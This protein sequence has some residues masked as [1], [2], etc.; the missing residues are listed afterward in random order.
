[1][2]NVGLKFM[3]Q[4]AQLPFYATEGA[5]G[6][7][8]T[9]VSIQY[10]NRFNQEVFPKSTE[11]WKEVTKVKYNLGLAFE[12]PK[13]YAI[14]LFPRSSVMK[15]ELIMSNSIGLIDCDY[16]GEVS[17]VFYLNE[18]SQLYEVGERCCQ[19]VLV[20]VPKCKFIVKKEL[21]ST[22]RGEGGYGHTGK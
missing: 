22:S 8:C 9:S 17:A 12:I 13:G 15:Q 21:S 16:R 19:I 6:A 10:F 3:H 14:L 18:N 20:E 11:E 1:M 7:D 4:D 5:A 2:V